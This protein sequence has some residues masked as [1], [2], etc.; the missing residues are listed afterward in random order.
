MNIETEWV[1]CPDCGE[2]IIERDGLR[3]DVAVF[4]TYGRGQVDM[5]VEHE[6]DPRVTP[7]P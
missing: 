1:L 2:P 5:D 3:V 4:G 6:C 7:A